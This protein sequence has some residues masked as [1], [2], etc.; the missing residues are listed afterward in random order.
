MNW[1][2]SYLFGRKQQV[3]GNGSNSSYL[4]V[5][6]GVPHGSVLLPSPAPGFY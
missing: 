6:F 3:S 2:K 1:F 4:D 5:T